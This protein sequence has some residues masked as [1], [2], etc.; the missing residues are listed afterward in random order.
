VRLATGL[1]AA[2]V[3]SSPFVLGGSV[4]CG[5]DGS[6]GIIDAGVVSFGEGS[7]SNETDG[8][9]RGSSS[10][11]S[12][13]GGGAASGGSPDGGG[14]GT[15]STHPGHGQNVWLHAKGSSLVD[16][17]GNTVRLFGVNRSGTEYA[18]VQG[19]GI[20]DGPS[21]AASVA[22]IKSWNAN[23]VRVPLNE[24]CWL[25]INGVQSAYSG[26][27]YQSAIVAYV[28]LLL[29]NG[30]YPI[31]D[32]HWTAP[33][34]QLATGQEPMPDADH[35]VAFWTSVASTFKGDANVVLELFNEPWPDNNQDTDEAWTCWLN[36]GTCSSVPYTVAGMQSLV[37]AVRQTGA[38]NLL[39]LGGVDYS[40]G[41]SHWVANK[42][43]DPLNN[44]AAAWH[45]YPENPCVTS[46]CWDANA[47]AV[48]QS[49]PIVATEVGDSDCD[50]TFPTSVMS[51]LDG[52]GQNYLAWTWDTFGTSCSNYSLVSDY[53]G[54]PNGA[55]G[56][57]FQS[58]FQ[59]VNP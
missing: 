13:D 45:V 5:A 41:L 22:A 15:G 18:C 55:Y 59:S 50:A 40:N 24:D 56:M 58:H 53:D 36:G 4:G 12:R 9:H 8:N 3:A 26:S 11:S 38:G 21:D 54:T 32:L 20:F 27:A 33:G 57:A 34:S 30:I 17:Q 29:E 28:M 51:W 25:G 52:H 10:T 37:S 44:L 42:P 23:A 31:V 16:A 14:S 43:N 2:L 7:S 39:L 19:F 1:L 35:S 6:G 46:S 49:Y 48:V 47:G